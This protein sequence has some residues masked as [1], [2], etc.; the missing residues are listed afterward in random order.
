MHESKF[1]M[2]ILEKLKKNYYFSIAD[3]SSV[4][5]LL[6]RVAQK[7]SYSLAMQEP[8]THSLLILD[9]FL[10]ENISQSEFKRK[11]QKL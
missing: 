4:P 8:L 9:A 7:H 6:R 2:I 11:Q 3:L 1:E 10:I 5:T